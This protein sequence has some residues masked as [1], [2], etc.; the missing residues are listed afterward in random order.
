MNI[1]VI[2]PMKVELEAV[3]KLASNPIKEEYKYI[4]GYSF[5]S[6]MGHVFAFEA[7]IGKT[8]MGFDLAYLDS[9]MKI[10]HVICLG[11]GGGL[12]KDMKPLDIAI[13]T[14][15]CYHDVDVR[16]FGKYKLGQLPGCDLYFEADKKIISKLDN[17]K[18]DLK[19]S[20][21]YKG[22]I[23]TG[24]QFA[25]S[26]LMT[27][28]L[29]AEFDNPICVDME[30]AAVGQICNRMHIPFNVIRSISDCIYQTSNS[31]Q[32]SMYN[33]FEELS[34]LQASKM[35]HYILNN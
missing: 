35:L 30:S 2:C 15:V 26:Y 18:L 3:I 29:L 25:T 21:L 10:D 4:S 32:A 5:E 1:V 20:K 24:D 12:L 31:S 19:D 13:A 33:N 16:V 6:K 9:I 14:K 27:P 23:I 8:N 22:L 28:S 34:S 11:V 7:S 17:F